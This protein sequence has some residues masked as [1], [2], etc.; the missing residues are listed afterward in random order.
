M[1]FTFAYISDIDEG[2]GLVRVQIDDL[3]GIT[4]DWIQVVYPKTSDKFFWTPTIGEYVFCI[5][6]AN[7]LTGTVLGSVY[8]SDT[9]HGKSKALTGVQFANGALMQYDSDTGKLTIDVTNAGD[10]EI[11][12]NDVKVNCTKA[13]ITASDSVDVNSPVLSCSGE[14]RA[15]GDI[16]AGNITPATRVRLLTH[17]HNSAVGPTLP[18]T[19]TP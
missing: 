4:S 9:E 5:F 15:N 11:I 19:P 13:T 2:T 17:T 14:I 12:A 10:I 7:Y 3:D 1:N 16:V 8:T 18:P 6:D